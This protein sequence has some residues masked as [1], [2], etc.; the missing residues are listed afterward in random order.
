MLKMKAVLPESVKPPSQ[1]YGKDNALKV[2]EL[3]QILHLKCH[4]STLE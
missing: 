1:V 2:M 3:F 4:A